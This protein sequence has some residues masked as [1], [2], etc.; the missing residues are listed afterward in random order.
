M[1]EL[2]NPGDSVQLKSGGPLM[3]VKVLDGNDIICVWFG[4]LKKKESRF[5]PAP[6]KH[7]EL[8]RGGVRA[9]PPRVLAVVEA[10]PRGWPTEA[11]HEEHARMTEESSKRKITIV[12]LIETLTSTNLAHGV[13]PPDNI[14]TL[15]SANLASGVAP[16]APA[17]PAARRSEATQFSRD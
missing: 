12:P 13:K 1:V 3:T 7:A 6:L 8:P 4:S 10:P 2:F 11:V 14:R 16:P 15:T 5:Q 17:A 9:T